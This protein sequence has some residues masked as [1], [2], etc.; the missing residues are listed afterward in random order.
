MRLTLLVFAVLSSLGF[1]RAETV[2]HRGNLA[3]SGTLDPA[4]QT[5]VGEYEIMSDLFMGLVQNSAEGLPIPG[6]AESWTVSADGR[7]TTFK[8]RDGLVWS[9]GVRMTADDFVY[10]FRR[11]LDPKTASPLAEMGAKIKNGAAVSAGKA[12]LEALGV[13]APDART[14]VIE[15]E[16]PSPVLIWLLDAGGVLAGAEARR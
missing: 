5:L 7:I 1:A 6:A 15:L 12:P 14:F 8:L 3:E 10:T 2:L 16:E 4:K 9:D 11:A 13:S